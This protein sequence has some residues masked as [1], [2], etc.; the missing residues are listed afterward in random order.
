MPQPDR[1]PG[2]QSPVEPSTS[3][4]LS[5]KDAESDPLPDEAPIPNPDESDGTSKY[6]AQDLVENY[7][8]SIQEA[9]RV[10][11]RFGSSAVD[12]DF[13]LVGKGRPRR[14]RAGDMERSAEEIAF[15]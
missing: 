10:I 14:H 4:F 6:T 13:I 9:R 1:S 15:G 12:L 7:G 11:D 3:P 2:T 8:L 5:T